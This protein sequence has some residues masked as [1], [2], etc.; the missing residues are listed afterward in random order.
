MS[1]FTTPRVEGRLVR[2]LSLGSAWR[3]VGQ[4]AQLGRGE[5][6]LLGE[7]PGWRSCDPSTGQLNPPTVTF[8]N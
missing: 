3:A 7:V 2:R 8:N 6:Q 1:V 4:E 5:R